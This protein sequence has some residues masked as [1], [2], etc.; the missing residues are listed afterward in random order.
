VFELDDIGSDLPSPPHDPLELPTA[1]SSSNNIMITHSPSVQ[2]PKPPKQ[3]SSAWEG[4]GSFVELFGSNSDSHPRLAPSAP[5]PVQHNAV[6]TSG[7][8]VASESSSLR[9]SNL[10]ESPAPP[11]RNVTIPPPPFSPPPESSLNQSTITTVTLLTH[12]PLK[13]PIPTSP[14]LTP[15]SSPRRPLDPLFHPHQLVLV[16]AL[17]LALVEAVRAPSC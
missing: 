1:P 6:V 11:P 16:F 7:P 2:R 13:L 3:R 9:P 15:P 12:P 10:L 14:G 4:S 8:G 17:S 5:L